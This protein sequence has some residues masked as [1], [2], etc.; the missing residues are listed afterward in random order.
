MTQPLQP[1]TERPKAPPIAITGTVSYARRTLR[2]VTAAAPLFELKQTA[3]IGHRLDGLLQT[4]DGVSLDRMQLTGLD[5]DLR[6]LADLANIDQG[7]KLLRVRSPEQRKLLMVVPVAF[8]TL[9]SQKARQTITT[10]ISRA[11]QELGMKVLFEVRGLDGVPPHRVQEVVAQLKP[12]CMAVVGSVNPVVRT[13]TGLAKCGLSGISL[14]YD[15]Q[16]R[17]DT[18]LRDYLTPLA[19]AARMAAGAC[20]VH[21]F[22]N[23]RQMA[24][25]RLA[26]ASHAGL[27][28]GAQPSVQAAN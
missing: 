25:A 21:G 3:M 23:V 9:A 15:G 2:V 26:G 18:Q 24:V 11:S 8:S 1:Q 7:L 6:E 12:S 10:T 20:M 19:E 22:E 17:D 16:R 4:E 5:W 13:I 27:R 28:A 14:D